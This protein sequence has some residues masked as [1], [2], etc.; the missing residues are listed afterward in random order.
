MRVSN[1]G[2][3]DFL[4]K[5]SGLVE[6]L[7][8]SRIVPRCVESFGAPGRR[9]QVN[10]GIVALV[11]ESGLGPSLLIQDRL[12]H[13]G[14]HVGSC[15][16]CAAVANYDRSLSARSRKVGESIFNRHLEPDEIRFESEKVLRRETRRRCSSRH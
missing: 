13:Y 7:G 11:P 15:V 8:A 16:H 9:H 1:P 10:Y 5:V 3:S 6:C 12:P 4:I 14:R 2:I